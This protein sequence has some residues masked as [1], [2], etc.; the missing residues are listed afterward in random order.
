MPGQ[1]YPGQ[2][3]YGQQPYPPGQPQFGGPGGY[4]QPP[5]SSGGSGGKI[6]LIIGGVAVVLIAVGVGAYF[7][8]GGSGSAVGGG[9]DDPNGVAQAWV[10]QQGDPKDLVCQAGLDQIEQYENQNPAAAPSGVPSDMP[11]PET[12]LESVD[13]PSGSDTGTFTMTMTMEML[14]E[15]TTS[16]ATYD[17]VKEDGGWKVCGILTPDI[18]V[19]TPGF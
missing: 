17:L 7:V 15:Q 2:P 3:Q 11:E 8:F 10:D 19:D 4:G 5:R 6:A 12:S 9:Y 13:V 1:P 14:G 16:K 18:D